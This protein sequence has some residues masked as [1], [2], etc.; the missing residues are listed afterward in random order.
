MGYPLILEVRSDRFQAL[1]HLLDQ[2]HHFKDLKT[3]KSIHANLL[4]TGFFFFSSLLRKLILAY[5]TRPG[6]DFISLSSLFN[7]LHKTNPIP[8]TSL[9]SSFSHLRLPFFALH[10]FSLMHRT[11]LPLDTYALCSALNASAAARALDFGKLV[12]THVS[13]SGCLPSVYVGSALIDVYVKSCTFDDAAKVF[14]EM[15]VRNTVCANALLLGYAEGKR[16]MDAVLL[17][18][19]MPVLRLEPD[20]Y[21]LSAA[22]RACTG[23]SAVELG[24][25][26]HAYGIRRIENLGS[27]VYLQSSLIEMYGRCGLVDNARNV[28]DLGAEMSTD[29]VLWTS[30]L[31]AY[32]RNGM[33]EDVIEFYDEMLIQ[34]MKPDEVVFV[35]LLTACS[36]TGHV[37]RGLEYFNSMVR[38]F[39]M[40]PWYEHYSCVVDM[41]CRAGELEK[42]WEMV[43]EMCCS[44]SSDSSSTVS[45]WGAL[46]N[47]CKDYGNVEMGRK[48]AQ[49]ALELDPENVGLYVVLSNLYAGA[50][51]WDEIEELREVMKDRGLKKPVGCSWIEST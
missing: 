26:V 22:L 24:R 10:C 41:L 1:Y 33:F 27:D 14:D 17:L 21:T 51:M 46:L 40:S 31:G 32:G 37:S 45:S 29:I 48:A 7:S 38:D 5:A 18:R 11:G 34:G 6:P 12:H 3:I 19:S 20:G 30:M 42:A 2:T 35:T 4:R 50:G 28:F 49:R 16:W 43:N 23:L 47:A 25:Q 13:K 39:A 15:P 36:H 44:R 8:W 9:V